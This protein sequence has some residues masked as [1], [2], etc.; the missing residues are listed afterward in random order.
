MLDDNDLLLEQITFGHV[1]RSGHILHIGHYVQSLCKLL[2]W[3]C[4]LT[5]AGCAFILIVTEIPS[6][7]TSQ[8]PVDDLNLFPV[9][10][11]IAAVVRQSSLAR[12]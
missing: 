8:C 11:R 1:Y 7:P 5:Y 9:V 12:R 3:C 2:G 6:C 4:F 10:V